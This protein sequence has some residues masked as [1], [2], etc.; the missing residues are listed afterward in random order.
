MDQAASSHV[1]L[2]CVSNS[3][4]QNSLQLEEFWFDSSILQISVCGCKDIANFQCPP[5][6]NGVEVARCTIVLMEKVLRQN[7]AVLLRLLQ[8]MRDGEI[9]DGD[10][11][12]LQSR[13]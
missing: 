6:D 3:W 1:A 13:C 7:K 4:C 11:D 2:A 5:L 9:D 8:H 10:V 12:L